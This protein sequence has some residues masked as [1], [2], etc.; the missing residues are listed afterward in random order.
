MQYPQLASGET[1]ASF[2]WD[3]SERQWVQSEGEEE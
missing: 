1:H 3:D 2:A